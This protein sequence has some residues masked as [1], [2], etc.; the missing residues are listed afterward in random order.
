MLNSAAI[1]NLAISVLV[2]SLTTDS[3]A[4][5]VKKARSAVN[6]DMQSGRY[7]VEFRFT[8][9]LKWK[10]A[11]VYQSINNNKEDQDVSWASLPLD[12]S[13]EVRISAGNTRVE[14]VLVRPLAFQIACSVRDQFIYVRLQK[15]VQVSVEINGDKNHPLLLF[16]DPP[17]LKPESN[18]NRNVLFFEKGLHDIGERYPLT[19]NTTYYLES[20]AYLMGSMYGDSTV[21]NVTI[22][23]R[24][25]INSGDHKWKHPT[26]G[27]LSNIAFEDGRNIRIDGIICIESGNF[28]IK[29]Q[30]KGNDDSILINNV[31]LIG[32]NKNTDGIHVSDMDWKDHPKVG[33]G[34]NIRL[35]IENCFIRANDD[36]VL[37]CDGVA[38]SVVRN[39]VIWDDGGGA[40]FCLSWGGHNNSDSSL[41]S[42]CYVIH[43]DGENPVFRALHAGEAILRHVRFEDIIIEGNAHTLVG[44]KITGHR[45]DPDPG[46]GHINDVYFSNITL[47]GLTN[48]N[49]IEGF[50]E[51]HLIEN[52]TFENLRIDGRII[53]S[54]KEMNLTTNDY[55]RNIV[56]K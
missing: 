49:Y 9:E 24:G 37:L 23:G 36:A 31:K 12:K 30:S 53:K 16:I 46:M 43:K 40:S 5:T 15:P 26:E 4:I 52:V 32:W 38:W 45:Y 10:E 20:G 56:F 1:K 18:G 48:G 13:V 47:E 2:F 42:N 54:S 14:S 17:E 39:C 8:D 41:V 27:L 6:A 34:D 28:Q 7:A 3:F 44:M 33:N 50:N 25:I 29:I 21:R 11:A 22:E 19:S 51:D 55:A 35:K